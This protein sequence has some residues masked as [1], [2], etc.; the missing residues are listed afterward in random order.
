MRS[1]HVS[2]SLLRLL[3]DIKSIFLTQV[4]FLSWLGHV[5]ELN[6]FA[7]TFLWS[8][9]LEW[10]L[11]K[12]A[13]ASVDFCDAN[14][15]K[16]CFNQ[17]NLPQILPG[18]SLNTRWDLSFYQDGGTEYISADTFH[19]WVLRCSANICEREGCYLYICLHVYIILLALFGQNIVAIFAV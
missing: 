13:S 16:I 8:E 19:L 12:T 9:A 15:Y 1:D 3:H 2:R 11:Y 17:W 14:D 4:R 10:N 18:N 5:Y 6:H 7:S